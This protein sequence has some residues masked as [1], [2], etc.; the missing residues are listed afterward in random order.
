MDFGEIEY[1]SNPNDKN[2][3]EENIFEMNSSYGDSPLEKRM[4]A[5]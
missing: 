5:F 2:K 4:K 3:T 1:R